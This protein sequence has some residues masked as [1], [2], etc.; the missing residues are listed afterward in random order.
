M[1]DLSRLI[2][3]VT[4]PDSSLQYFYLN[5][6]NFAP[7]RPFQHKLSVSLAITN[8]K[9][10]TGRLFIKFFL[11]NKFLAG[12]FLEISILQTFSLDV[13]SDSVYVPFPSNDALELLGAI[14]LCKAVKFYYVSKK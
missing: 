4:Y 1:L 14:E 7:I 5:P 13:P 11:I 3:R 12:N 2:V 10:T 8:H 6:E 9:P